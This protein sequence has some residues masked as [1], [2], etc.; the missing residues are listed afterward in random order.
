DHA[1]TIAEA[2]GQLRIVETELGR[3]D[4]GGTTEEYAARISRPLTL[5]T[6]AASNLFAI[7]DLTTRATSG[8]ANLL[9]PADNERAARYFRRLANGTP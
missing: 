5:L 6:Q 3:L 2:T 7:A 1:A 4:S 9:L 8:D